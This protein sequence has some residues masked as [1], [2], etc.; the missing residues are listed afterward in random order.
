MRYLY[1]GAKK[2][3]HRV[4]IP[5]EEPD[6]LFGL[7]S[8]FVVALPATLAGFVRPLTIFGGT[9]GLSGHVAGIIMELSRLFFVRLFL[10]WVLVVGHGGLL[11]LFK[12]ADLAPPTCGS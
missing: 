9:D 10:I 12:F 4:V 3:R 5:F 2:V 8:G 6:L 11:G 7:L 1:N